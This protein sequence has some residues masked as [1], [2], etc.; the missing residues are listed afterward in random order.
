[1][2]RTFKCGLVGTLIGALVAVWL[3]FLRGLLPGIY[4]YEN[5][6]LMT[7]LAPPTVFLNIFATPGLRLFILVVVI[8]QNAILYGVLGWIVGK[9]WNLLG[10]EPQVE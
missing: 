10:P 2:T 4:V 8:A 6:L 5:R 7:I 3:I 9:I 1:V